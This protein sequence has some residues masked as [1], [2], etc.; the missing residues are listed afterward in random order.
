MKPEECMERVNT[1]RTCPQCMTSS[2]KIKR[3]KYYC[4]KTGK[5][6][7]ENIDGYVSK[8]NLYRILSTY[9]MT[10]VLTDNEKNILSE[11]VTAI[12]DMPNEI[13]S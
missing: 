10:H 3:G 11:L 1:C 6:I 13:D 7:L 2:D 4:G 12:K 8:D 5:N 9:R